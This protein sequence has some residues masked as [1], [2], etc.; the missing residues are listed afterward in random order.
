MATWDQ[1]IQA[2]TAHGINFENYGDAGAIVAQFD[3]DPAGK[4]SQVVVMTPI[5]LDGIE[6]VAVQSP[7][8]PSTDAKKTLEVLRAVSGAPFGI[9]DDG[10]FLVLRTAMPLQDLDFSEVEFFMTSVYTLADLLEEQ[11]F[12]KDNF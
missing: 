7:I 3:T 12:H 11:V 10:E 6:F 2:L 8:A 1:L 5:S 9:A 4:R